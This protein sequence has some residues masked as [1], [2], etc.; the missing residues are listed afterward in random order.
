M[1]VKLTHERLR[2]RMWIEK[3]SL[4]YHGKHTCL[5]NSLNEEYFQWPIDVLRESSPENS[6]EFLTIGEALFCQT[7]HKLCLI[8]GFF[9]SL[10][11]DFVFQDRSWTYC[12][13]IWYQGPSGAEPCSSVF[14]ANLVMQRVSGGAFKILSNIL[15][16]AKSKMECFA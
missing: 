15:D 2:G 3:V 16:E 1:N 14:T 13:S 5:S 12:L 7:L 4:V 10:P 8:K 9:V 11:E 6:Y